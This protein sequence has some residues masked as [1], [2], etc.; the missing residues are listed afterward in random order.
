MRKLTFL[1]L[2]ILLAPHSKA[3][4]ETKPIFKDS[5]V[6]VEARVKDLL[7]RMTLAEK[8]LQLNQ[9]VSGR[10]TNVNNIGPIA[11]TIPA[12]IGSI[13]FQSSDP[14]FR[15]QFQKRAM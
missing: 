15:N 9:Y 5:K 1:L 10:N 11:T 6:P 2:L 13:L 3:T 7:S 14:V 8:I 4:N 12:G